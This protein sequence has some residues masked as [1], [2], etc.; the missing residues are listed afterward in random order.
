[1][2]VRAVVATMLFLIMIWL[3]HPPPLEFGTIA[4]GRS[5]S[6]WPGTRRFGCPVIKW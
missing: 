3:L 6:I 2:K 5:E 1:M 4:A